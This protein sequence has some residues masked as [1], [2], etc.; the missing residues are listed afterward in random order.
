MSSQRPVLPCLVCSTWRKDLSVYVLTKNPTY[1]VTH[2]IS[3]QTSC[4]KI[5]AGS[6]FSLLKSWLCSCNYL[7]M[8]RRI[9]SLKACPIPSWSKCQHARINLFFSCKIQ[10][11]CVIFRV[12][13]KAWGAG[14]SPSKVV[15]HYFIDCN[16]FNL[17]L[18]WFKIFK[19]PNKFKIP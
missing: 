17:Q 14:E 19:I 2:V 6:S 18:K 1:V 10:I 3:W 8:P 7:E 5:L 13:V 15:D 11:T 12:R 9:L 16:H 4:K